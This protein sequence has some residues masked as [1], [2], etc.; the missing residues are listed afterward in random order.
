MYTFHRYWCLKEA[1]VKAVGSGL[2]SGLD[3]VEFHN[4]RWTSIS[5]KINGEDMREWGF[6]LSEMGKRHLVSS[7][8]YFNFMS[9]IEVLALESL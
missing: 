1:F 4:T 6:W 7:S 5:V 2:A 9:F 8:S 3:K